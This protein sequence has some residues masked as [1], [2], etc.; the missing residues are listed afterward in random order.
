MNNRVL[1]TL[2]LIGMGILL[3]L[4]IGIILTDMGSGNLP[5]QRQIA[6]QE[7][8]DAAQATAIIQQ[9]AVA[10]AVATAQFVEAENIKYF[11]PE[12]DIEGLQITDSGLRY[13]VVR[14]ADGV[15][16]DENDIVEVDY[17]GLFVNGQEFDS[18]YARGE[19][20]RFPLNGVIP[21]WTEGLQLMSVGSEFRFYIPPELA[22]GAA[23]S[24]PIPGNTP[25]F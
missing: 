12:P 9:T 21:G 18:S 4:F 16:P 23:G 19:T 6:L 2:A 20:A 1:P 13:E 14:E 25:S 3:V 5:A 24:G 11:E 10:E 15:I 8:R 22:Y 17:R 7:T